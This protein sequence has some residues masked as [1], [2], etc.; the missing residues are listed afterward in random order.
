M[1]NIAPKQI[2]AVSDYS[3]IRGIG[4][5][6]QSNKYNYDVGGLAGAGGGVPSTSFYMDQASV[7]HS[8]Q[9]KGGN[10]SARINDLKAR[11]ADQRSRE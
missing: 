11:V 3:G 4:N 6:S 9:S 2:T 7:R 10:A 8:Q 1:N 5:A